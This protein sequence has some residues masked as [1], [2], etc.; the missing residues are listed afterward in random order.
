M[1]FYFSTIAEIG[2][3]RFDT[4]IMTY[5]KRGKIEGLSL[6]YLVDHPAGMS[7]DYVGSFDIFI[8]SYFIVYV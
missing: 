2:W 4:Y 8:I 7:Q 3:V 1:W 6:T 5:L